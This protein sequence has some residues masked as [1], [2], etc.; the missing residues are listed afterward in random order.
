MHV[1][2]GAPRP[3]RG[4]AQFRRSLRQLRPGRRSPEERALAPHQDSHGAF[5]HGNPQKCSTG[6]LQR[7][8]T[9]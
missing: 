5:A 2:P 4:E 1:W 9:F 8:A 7:A 6:A 3:L